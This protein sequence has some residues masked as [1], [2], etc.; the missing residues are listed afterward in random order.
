MKKIIILSTIVS[1][2]LG[3]AI[4]Y[5]IGNRNTEPKNQYVCE[6]IDRIG[7]SDISYFIWVDP[8]YNDYPEFYAAEQARV[9]YSVAVED[10]PEISNDS[11]ISCW[12]YEE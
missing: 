10:D 5:V 1:L 7:N 12:V 2:L 9:R 11:N 6:V 3:G 8:E 4:G